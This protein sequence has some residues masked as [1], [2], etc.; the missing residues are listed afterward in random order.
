MPPNA[1]TSTTVQVCNNNASF[2]L[3][4]ALDGT[5]DNGG[6]WVDDDNS[7]VVFT[8]NEV[9]LTGLEP[10]TYRFTYSLNLACGNAAATV[11]VEVFEAPNAGA[12]RQ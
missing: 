1:G 4:D 8:G 2:D 3:L 10:G 11:T 5:P 7:G 6:T 12:T 9:D